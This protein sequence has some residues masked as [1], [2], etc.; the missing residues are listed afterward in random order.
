MTMQQK[1]QSN[2]LVNRLLSWLPF[3]RFKSETSSALLIGK[4]KMV[5]LPFL[6]LAFSF[7]G[8]GQMATETFEGGLPATW[9]LLGSP[10]ATINW[11][12]SNDG[13][14]GGN[15]AMVNPAS[16]NIGQGNSAQYFLVT[17]S[18][19][20]PVK[21]EIRFLSK[22]A[23]NT[24]NENITYQLRLSTATQPDINGFSVILES[25]PGNAINTGADNV[26][27]EKIIAI[28]ES[29]PANLQIF[30]AFVA[31]NNQ[32]GAVASGDA[33]FVDNVRMIESCSKVVDTDFNAN[34]ITPYTAN[35]SW[36]HP[37]ASDF[38]ILVLP[39]GTLPT[40]SGTVIQNSYP[41]AG[42]D[43]D[44][45]YDVYIRTVCDATTSSG[46]AGPFSFKTQILGLS[47]ATPI[48][49]PITATPYIFTGN[50]DAFADNPISYTTHGTGCL[51]ASVTENHLAGSK[52]FFTY[53]PTANG[54][55]NIK[56]FT[57]PYSQG[58]GCFGNGITG[59]FVYENCAAVGV[60][61]MAG[62]NTVSPDEPK[63]ISNLYVEAGHTYTIVISSSF[64]ST[65]SICF[66]FELNFSACAAPN[67]YTY[68]NLLQTSVSFSWN[69][70]ANL[71]NSWEYVVQPAGTGVPT[72]SGTVTNT[73]VDNVI[74]TGLA[75]GIA[76]E[77]YVR[78]NCTGTPGAWGLP[79]NFT[80]QCAPFN[81][82]YITA[83]TDR[84][85][86]NPEPCWTAVD[87]DGDGN[88][89]QYAAGWDIPN[90]VYLP[91]S[92]N[93]NFNHDILS[94]PQV[95]FDSAPKRLRYKYEVNYGAT[96]YSIKLSTTGIG[97][98]N[99]T[100]DILP[101]TVIDNTEWREKIIN[102]P[103]GIAGNV[104]IA[105]IVSPGT[106]SDAGRIMFSDVFI[107][108][109][110]AC[111]D[112]IAP[113]AENVTRTTAELSW[114]N[115]DVETQWQVAIQPL[116]TGLPTGSGVLVNSNP[117]TAQNLDPST[118][119][120]Y[121]VRAYCDATHQ[122]QW[123]G[124]FNFTT[125]CTS[126]NTPYRES[127][128]D[129]DSD[130][131]KFC[132]TINNANEDAA[133][134]TM[135][136]QYPSIRP[137]TSWF[138]PT[139][140]FDDYLISPAINAVGTKVLKFDYRAAFSIFA[141]TS[142]FG[143]EVLISTTDTNPASFTVLVPLMEF[144]NT[145][146]LQKVAYFEGTGTTYIA[147]RVPP[148]YSLEGGSS[149]LQLD[150]VI[151]EDAPACPKPSD[152][153][154]TNISQNQA[155]LSWHAGYL[156]EAWSVVVQEAG[157]GIPTVSGVSVTDPTDVPNT[158]APN[159]LYEF[160]VKAN[161]TSEN[162]EWAG[163]FVFRTLCNVFS[164][165][166]VETFNSNSTS[167]E[168]WRILNA[169]SDG[170]QW[171]LQV[172]VNPYEG[173]QMAGM[174]TGSN[175]AND[176][177]LIS[178]TIN[179]TG[180]QRL[181]FYYKVYHSD[182]TEDLEIK[183]STSGIDLASF[184]TTLYDSA[185]ETVLINNME[186][187]E[188][189]I[190]LP[191]GITGNINIAW[192][193]PEM[194]PSWMGY[195]G[196]LLFID[197]VIVEDIPACA[198]V[199]NPVVAITGITDTTFELGWEANGT[200]TSWE[201]S[202]QPYGTP[203]PTGNTLPEYL[204]TATTNPYTVTGLTPATK[205][206]YYIRA[207][208]SET[209]QSEWVGPFTVITKCSFENLCQYTITL[210]GGPTGGIGGGINVIQN[211]Y[212]IQTM[213]FP[214]GPWN[215]PVPPVD[216]TLFLCTGVEFSLYWD[217]IGT[218]PGQF[219]G[220]TVT[221]KNPA[222][223]VVSTTDLGDL[224]A[225][226]STFFTG[227]STC[228][229]IT[230]P[231]PTSLNVN[232]QSSFSWTAGGTETSW[233]VFIQPVGNNTLPQSGTI[234]TTPGYTPVAADF[235]SD[236]A[237]TF[238][239]F[240]RAICSETNKS[241]WSG[242]KVFIRNDAVS[243]AL[244][245]AVNADEN[246][247]V[248]TAATFAGATVSSEP[249]SCGGIN[250][251]DV[252]FEF[253][254]TSKVHIIEVNGFTGNFYIS[255][256][257]Q[258]Y[259]NL[260]MTL[261]QVTGSGL[262]EK[263]CSNN[264]SI[265]AMYSS[266]LVVGDTYK[267]RL[268]LNTLTGNT[269]PFNVC[270]KTPLDL[271]KV[272][273]VN[274]DFETPP[275][276]HVT[277]VTTIGTQYVVPGWRTNLDTWEAIFFSEALNAINFAPYSGG[278]CIQLLSDPEED[279]DPADPNIK[280]LYK[281]FDTSQMT[282]M[283][284]SFAHATRSEGNIIQLYAGPKAGPFVL[285]R[286]EPA[287][288][289][290]WTLHTG[291]YD[292]PAG[293]NETR[294]IFRTKE[295]K[296]GNLLDAANF[297]ANNKIETAP[298]TLACDQRA[299]VL[300][301]EGIGN[302][303]ASESNP[304]ATVIES[305]AS[306]VTTIS[307]FTAPGV[308]TYH[309]KTSYCDYEITVTYEGFA[310]VPTVQ[311]PIAYCL[312][313]TA[314]PLTATPTANYTLAWF[315]EE[316]GGTGTTTAPTPSTAA[317]GTTIYYVANVNAAGCAGIR[318][319]I[320]VIVNDRLTQEVGFNYDALQYC[321]LAANPIINLNTGFVTGGQFSV[322][323]AGLDL[324]TTTGAITLANSDA[325]EYT[326]VYRVNA[327]DCADANTHPVT[328]TVNAA[329][330]AVIGF[331]YATPICENSTN[332]LPIIPTGFTTGGT[333]SSTTLTVNGTTGAI[334][335]TT[336]TAGLH[337][338]VYNVAA[339]VAGCVNSG[340]Q[341]FDIQINATIVPVTGFMFA[342]NYCATATNPLPTLAPGFATGGIF[343]SSTGL[344]ID[345]TTGEINLAASP[346]GTHQ[347]TYTILPSGCNAG[348]STPAT[349]TIGTTVNAVVQ[350]T[351]NNVCSISGT[352]PLPSLATGF[353]TGGTFNAT[354][355]GLQINTATG[356]I[357]LA[358]STPGT[359]D[360]T[361][362]V[363]ANGCISGGTHLSSI[364]ISAAATPEVSFSYSAVCFTA[365]I[366]PLPQLAAGFVS[367][368]VFSSPTVTVN[369]ATGLVDLATAIVGTHQITYTLTANP[370]ACVNGAT[371]NANLSITAA[372]TAVTGFTYADSY[373]LGN[374]NAT[375][376]L[377]TG[378]TTGGVF[379]ATTGLVIDP[380]SGTLNISAS[381]LGNHRVTYTVGSAN[382]LV[383][384][385]GFFDLAITEGDFDINVTKGCDGNN[386]TLKATPIDGSFDPA[387]ANY[388]WKDATGVVGNNSE[389]FN[390]TAYAQEHPTAVFPVTFTVTVTS[391]SCS[392]EESITIDGITCLNIPRGISPNGDGDNDTFDLSGMGVSYIT[393]FNRYGT[394]VF[395]F[396]GNYS[397]QWHGQSKDGKDLPTATYFYSINK[398]DGTAVTGWVYINR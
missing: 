384:N 267:I 50:L 386:L 388:V 198:N 14:L 240:V 190:N 258:A 338:I 348:G 30:I 44:T 170:N 108:D 25:W 97:A 376:T 51:S 178:P 82:P 305:P 65:A 191:A 80:T 257:D 119:Y 255:S 179:T 385:T 333:F 76:Y 381:T 171:S 235:N 210:S 249:M 372:I 205:Y 142:R 228:G 68:K 13:Y 66:T 3:Y 337:T 340:T 365:G 78:S 122:S 175:G 349:V 92:S 285:I 121:Y 360:I 174:F 278:Q 208:C 314:T 24:G 238:E 192:H 321:K 252:W 104:N 116:G 143:V 183:L 156:E 10:S 177:W 232:E 242:P 19:P 141:P 163:P 56:Q 251:G 373:C 375:P 90:Y 140:S 196:Q 2:A 236:S 45:N 293:Q 299:T 294:F 47:C 301:A 35:L 211:G 272:N 159:T 127:F 125:L 222:G 379:T 346:T 172:T 34:D 42:L 5:L 95:I 21:G 113:I 204:Q 217:S 145:D 154:A 322:T 382:C 288:G 129:S 70:P 85:E 168:C 162:S 165:P 26:Y 229:T 263:A 300:T 23:T 60:N 312:N 231:Q 155:S 357:T 243:T 41:A 43:E 157:L 75:A 355:T 106:D 371:V 353:T 153:I 4:N 213:D 186:Y 212:V 350:F 295:N 63:Y 366:N 94:A 370:T 59:V 55:L 89:W 105:W 224:P 71:A 225:P 124:P 274:Y 62:L 36:T 203:A 130:T 180:N 11:G 15:A 181:R 160:Y 324:N 101:E 316:T 392:N 397:N 245:V 364:T 374:A 277:G 250:G 149:I 20:V 339:N 137:S 264:N 221:V 74:N 22:R 303:T 102:L 244:R 356:E 167:K 9:R 131:K 248:S 112:P 387:T 398:Q 304:A 7:V 220:A 394:E 269:R 123:I 146:F 197:N 336:A 136:A 189:V 115:G 6:C 96:K 33:W 296:I 99:F 195:R 53:T 369:P 69:N 148:E 354:P 87:V 268:S 283:E 209:S 46:W 202:V 395:S 317:T 234:V 216:F 138:D 281:D 215:E 223:E 109:K 48:V 118:R 380:A 37:T 393:I 86:T 144:T 147:F 227:V 334:D 396:N 256:G 201:I 297:Y 308:Y 219:P 383:G 273:A 368:G 111:P 226:R 40:G 52:A 91:L 311:T 341:N 287:I 158:L 275:M 342:P 315:T 320:S 173:D 187:K 239:Y 83:F 169:N 344:I 325:G 286:E 306:K 49:I 61:C 332:V 331:T 279:W 1:L 110:P 319:P 206:E 135:E 150:N 128:N 343:A 132:W 117:Y 31:V 318:V 362:N 359:Y 194:E 28:P 289:L 207:I 326:I 259:P 200:E 182:F 302:W 309:W 152:L 280:G 64:E 378:F 218:A 323:P 176:D 282:Q 358:G 151:I 77:L 351:Y 352:N 199:S 214:T 67:E 241:F 164:T 261:Y 57:L 389:T 139:T 335:M 233:E 133:L 39:Q 307:G 237:T 290:A 134:W 254:A 260:N 126:F 72:G 284:Y 298:V 184:T 88:S 193:I 361:Y 266:E 16:D 271:C 391:G 276:H 347:I 328:L 161:C 262:T 98:Q 103:A 58:S 107:E 166:F 313:A 291:K 17:P 93:Q 54:L 230:C 185:V 79:Y 265:T 367:G 100:V 120:E 29:I 38:E 345:A 27:E 81:V 270:I 327:T 73:N 247:T 246:C 84:S 18:V 12:I 377:A 8:Y 32:T 330:N 188:M 310:D 363:N 292:I 390:A 114:A 253:V 329:A